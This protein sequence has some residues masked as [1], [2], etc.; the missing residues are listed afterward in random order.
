MK[1]WFAELRIS[2]ALDSGRMPATW[3]QRKTD[4]SDELRGFEQEMTA[5]DRALRQTAPKPHAPPSLHGSIMRAVQA[6]ERPVANARGGLAFLRWLPV[7][8]VAVLALM[9][10]WLAGRGPVRPPV[11]DTQSLAVATTAFQVG[12]QM[13]RALPSAVVNPLADELNK[14]NLD[15]NNTAQFLLA[16]LP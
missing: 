10:V 16:S 1:A 4:V 7:P 14:I 8:V 9:V 6:A 3:S 5:L 11:Q 2:A 12:G 13:A 15:L